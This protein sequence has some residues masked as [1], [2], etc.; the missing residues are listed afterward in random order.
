MFSS[1][2]ER[3]QLTVPSWRTTM[4]HRLGGTG[5]RAHAH[6][7][8]ELILVT[9]G[10]FIIQTEDR[11]LLGKVGDLFVIPPYCSHTQPEKGLVGTSY[12]GFYH[13]PEDF[14]SSLRAISLTNEPFLLRWFEDIVDLHNIIIDSKP[15]TEVATYLLTAIVVRLKQ[16]ERHIE[17]AGLINPQLQKALEYIKNNAIKTISVEQIAESAG[18]SSSYLTKLFKHT[19]G[20][21]PIQ[22]QQKLRMQLACKCLLSP[23]MTVKHTARRCGYDNISLFIRIFRKH[24]NMSPGQWHDKFYTHEASKR[25]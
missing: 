21:S 15:Y 7:Y 1:D 12:I 23:Y 18:I 2:I 25:P 9:Q 10:N 19:L 3:L 16:I 11:M 8:T 20:Q 14:D 6:D 4:G 13:K 24:Y 17:T 22:Y 5:V